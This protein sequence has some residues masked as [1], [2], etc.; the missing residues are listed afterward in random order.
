MSE[1]KIDLKISSYFPSGVIFAGGVLLS[2]GFLVAAANANITVCI[3]LLLIGV[4]LTTTHYRL[5]INQQARQY[6]D[7]VWFLGFKNGQSERFESLDYIFIKQKKVSKNLNS[8]ISSRTM[9][10]DAFDGYL[11][12]DGNE[13][14][15]L[16]TLENKKAITQRLNRIAEKLQLKVV[17]YSV[18]AES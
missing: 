9:I 10:T 3:V 12:V 7:Y 18:D 17:D 6:K 16:L 15:H 13:T 2:A 11:K 8:R 5:E 4:I 14:I 1:Q